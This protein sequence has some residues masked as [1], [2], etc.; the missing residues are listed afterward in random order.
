M[1]TGL[2]V[3]V[4]AAITTGGGLGGAYYVFYLSS[5]TL[6]VLAVVFCLAIFNS[7]PT[8]PGKLGRFEVSQ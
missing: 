8:E 1:C 7:Y 3:L 4:I 5:S 6:L 2:C